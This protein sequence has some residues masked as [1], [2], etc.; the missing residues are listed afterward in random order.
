MLDQALSSAQAEVQKNFEALQQLAVKGHRWLHLGRL[1]PDITPL[2]LLGAL[3]DNGDSKM[4]GFVRALALNY[5]KSIIRL[6]HLLRIQA[7]YR[8]KDTIQ[9]VSE[10]ASVP[11]V[12]WRVEDHIDWLL[13]EI[14]F[15]LII[16][17]DQIRVAFAMI[18]SPSSTSN[19]VLQMN[20]GQGKSSVVIPMI[21]AA[22]AGD[23]NLVRVVVPRSLLLQAAQLLTS[24]LGGLINRRVKHIPFSRKTP[25]DIASIKAYHN[26]HLGILSGRG[27]ILTL[28]EHLLSIQLSGKQELSN[29]CV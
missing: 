14:D 8:R 21:A 19:F 12:G 4:S 29:G 6:Q 20:M 22:L 1:L 9:L 27:V 17:E 5:A 18:A 25:T 10:T 13:L 7:A 24:R 15:N 11:H 2:S 26:L 3:Q 28:P 23:K 16:R